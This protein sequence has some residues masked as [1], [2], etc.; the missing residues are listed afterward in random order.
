MRMNWRC[1]IPYFTVIN[2]RKGLTDIY[3][4]S[5]IQGCSAHRRWA[6]TLTQWL[7]KCGLFYVYGFDDSKNWAWPPVATYC[8]D[9]LTTHAT[10]CHISRALRL[11]LDFIGLRISAQAFLHSASSLMWFLQQR[12]KLVDWC[13]ATKC[14]GTIVTCNTFCKAIQVVHQSTLSSKTQPNF[15]L[16]LS[17]SELC[18]LFRILLTDSSPRPSFC[19][20]LSVYQLPG[21]QQ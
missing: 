2:R 9:R 20:V 12:T 19:V 3:V 10:R 13:P 15:L 18:S 16:P 21:S 1:Q 8:V 11:T 14:H 5:A 7:L 4:Q 6:V 17:H